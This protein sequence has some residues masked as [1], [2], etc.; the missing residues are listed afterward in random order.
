MNSYISTA[1]SVC[2]GH[3]DK[4]SDQ[5]SDTILDEILM[6][7]KYARV[8]CETFVTRG[9]VIVGGEITTNASFD[10]IEIARN[11]IRDIGYTRSEFGFHWQTCGILNV[12]GK[13][14]PDI[15]QGVDRG[16]AGDQGCMIGYAC[17]ETESYMPYAIELANKLTMRIDETRK[18]GILPYLGPDG[19][20][21]VT[22]KH[23][24]EGQWELEAVVISAQHTEEILNPL[25]TSNIKDEKKDEIIQ[26]VILSVIPKE[27]VKPN[28]RFYINPT[29]KFV[30]GGPLSDT[31]MSGRKIIVDTYGCLV[32]HGGGAFSGKDPT[33]VDRSAAYFARYL[34][35]NVVASGIA[36]ECLVQLAYIIGERQPISFFLSTN[37]T[38]KIDERRIRDTLRELVDLTPSGIIESLNLRRP[39]YRKTSVYGHFGRNIPEFTW[40]KLDLVEKIKE[41]LL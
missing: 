8:A 27:L 4:V 14:S 16:G 40:E 24:D 36:K 1:E 13:Q 33:K 31:G 6:Q 11:V 26:K 2:E 3:P 39:I 10:A 15:S 23:N 41:K 30:I 7:D 25:D 9:I 38:S 37:N 21:Q 34:A 12:I 17:N 35:K 28:T 18:N 5:I 32:P 29:G 20:S 22:I 19:K